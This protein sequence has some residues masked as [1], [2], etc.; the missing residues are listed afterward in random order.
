MKEK[1]DLFVVIEKN[2]KIAKNEML[3]ETRNEENLSSVSISLPNFD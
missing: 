3:I 1:N 2:E